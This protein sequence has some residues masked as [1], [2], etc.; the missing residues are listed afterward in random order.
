MQPDY[1]PLSLICGGIGNDSFFRR[2]NSTRRTGH[3]MGIGALLSYW[4]VSSA[5]GI[6]I[7][8]VILT[9][10]RYPTSLKITYPPKKTPL[11]RC[12]AGA[13]TRVRCTSQIS[14]PQG[15]PYEAVV[16]PKDA[17]VIPSQPDP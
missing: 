14:P 4:P 12:T 3:I 11:N 16:Y 7:P 2:R 9:K 6:W 15:R 17:N 8:A 5:I 10:Y 1:G 13:M